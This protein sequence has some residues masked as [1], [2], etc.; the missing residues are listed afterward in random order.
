MSTAIG[1]TFL[2]ALVVAV[3]AMWYRRSQAANSGA[4]SVSHRWI[5]EHRAQHPQEGP[6]AGAG[7]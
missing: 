2:L 1:L 5:S 4:G 6:R 7:W 3:A